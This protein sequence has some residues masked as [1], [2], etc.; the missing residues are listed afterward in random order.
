[1]SDG[2]ILGYGYIQNTTDQTYIIDY[3]ISDVC[4]LILGNLLFTFL[5]FCKTYLLVSLCLCV[6]I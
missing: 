4:N 5:F 6:A 1:M 3:I 2:F